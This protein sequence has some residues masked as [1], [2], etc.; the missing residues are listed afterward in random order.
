MSVHFHGSGLPGPY[1]A[2]GKA[3]DIPIVLPELV[4]RS[5]FV[6]GV[7]V[8]GTRK[9]RSQ[10]RAAIGGVVR[11]SV[12]HA[13]SVSGHLNTTQLY[14][15]TESTEKGGISFRLGMG[16]AAAVASRVL[17]VEQTMHVE[18]FGFP[19]AKRRADLAGRDAAGNWHVIEAKGWSSSFGPRDIDYAKEQARE[20]G[21]NFAAMG[22]RPLTISACITDLDAQPI[23]VHF[24]DPPP[25][26]TKGK[27]R[28]RFD[29]E[30]FLLD[31]YL[32]VR[33][34]IGD[35]AFGPP[36]IDSEATAGSMGSWLP[37]GD[38]WIGIDRRLLEILTRSPGWDD[39][40]GVLADSALESRQSTQEHSVFRGNDGHVVVL[41]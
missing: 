15:Q 33:D 24:H 34:L 27:V 31:Y 37:G 16:F 38:I 39:V 12:E 17:R 25:R 41:A 22:Q 32:P 14:R 21:R 23:T 20:T 13:Q 30:S 18:A 36:P 4:H 10:R 29:P 6:G 28:H 40:T 11:S 2:W 8:A 5:I 26:S 7:P 1:R 19:Q 35:G 3:G 9:Q